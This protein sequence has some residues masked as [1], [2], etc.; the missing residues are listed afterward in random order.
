MRVPDYRN[1]AGA[2][3]K[4]DRWVDYAM[5]HY[6]NQKQMNLRA[7]TT[8]VSSARW[9]SPTSTISAPSVLNPLQVWVFAWTAATADY[10]APT[11]ISI[12]EVPLTEGEFP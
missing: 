7:N 10:V 1:E 6:G 4:A 9:L 8:V 2:G 12:E 3:F 5:G 11:Y